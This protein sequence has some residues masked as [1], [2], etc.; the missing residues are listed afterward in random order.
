MKLHTLSSPLWS[1][2]LAALFCFGLSA[3]T[4]Q[5][6]NRSVT[7][8]SQRQRVD[9]RQ[10][11]VLYV[12]GNHLVVKMQDGQVRE[13]EIPDNETFDIDGKQVKV[14]E[15][16]PGTRLTR[17]VTTTTQDVTVSRILTVDLK[18]IQVMPPDLNV[19]Y[20]DGTQKLLRVPEGTTFDIDGKTMKL[21]DLRE[22]MRVKGTV[23]TKTPQTVEYQ[24]KTV[25]GVAPI[26]IPTTVGAL[27]IEEK[28][29]P[30]ASKKEA[31]AA[32]EPAAPETAARAASQPAASEAAAPAAAQ[33]TAPEST[34][35]GMSPL[36]WLGLIALLVIVI[37]ILVRKSRAKAV[38]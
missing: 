34:G 6:A 32:A 12:A 4:P 38:M 7:V 11:T 5:D 20:A 13:F 37:A 30:E 35:T 14:S 3:Q 9:V 18:V 29:E 23:V 21:T 26:E 8:N 10:G 1:C 17:A 19:Q 27:L 24:S 25:S 28:R 2:G 15:L 36:L 31:A 16:K 33:P 22:G